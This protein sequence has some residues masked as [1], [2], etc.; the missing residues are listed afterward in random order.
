MVPCLMLD[1]LEAEPEI[2]VQGQVVQVR[3]RPSVY[4]K[5]HETGKARQAALTVC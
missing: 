5:G 1:P 3:G 2:R 4:E